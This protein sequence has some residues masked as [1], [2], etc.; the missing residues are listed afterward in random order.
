[1]LDLSTGDRSSLQCNYAHAPRRCIKCMPALLSDRGTFK[2]Q[3]T[4]KPA[5]VPL[6]ARSLS[7]GRLPSDILADGFG[8]MRSLGSICAPLKILKLLGKSQNP[9]MYHHVHKPQLGGH[10]ARQSLGQTH[11]PRL[12]SYCD[13]GALAKSTSTACAFAESLGAKDFLC[14]GRG[15]LPALARASFGH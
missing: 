13:L 14:A 6:G 5:G 2:S 4:S 8:S 12:C 3:H 11:C 7:L 1:M 10:R 9:A 15:Q